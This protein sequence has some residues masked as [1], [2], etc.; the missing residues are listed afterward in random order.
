[1][2]SAISK[3]LYRFLDKRFFHGPRWEFNLKE[4]AWEKV[5]LAR[6]YDVGNL[7]RKLR[8]AIGELE[9]LGFLAKM[10][11]GE[12]FRKVACGDW[13]AVFECAGRNRGSIAASQPPRARQIL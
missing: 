8:P 2:D 12:R 13:R 1:L 3:R 9:R 7:K 5:G 4:L 6:S 10:P 11:D